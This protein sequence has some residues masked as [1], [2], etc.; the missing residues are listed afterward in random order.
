MDWR[1]IDYALNKNVRLSINPDA[2][3]CEGLHDMYYGTL[4]ARKG[5]LYKEMCLNA[6]S[7]DEI[8]IFF[9]R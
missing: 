1:W 8:A 7:R 6:M 4:V 3:E 9:N 5:G 2:H